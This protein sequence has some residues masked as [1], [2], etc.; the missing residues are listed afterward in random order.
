MRKIFLYSLLL[1]I[2]LIGSQ[3][4][5]E[6]VGSSDHLVFEIINFL[7]MITLAYI[8]IK[9][10]LEFEIDKSKIKSYAWDYLVAMVSAA[11]PW[12]FVAFYFSSLLSREFFT[13]WDTWKELLL[14]SRFAAP[15]SAGVL[16][17]MLAAAGLSATWL[18]K[19]IRILAIFDDLDTILFMI[20]LQIVFIG[21]VWQL[22]VLLPFILLL[23]V[24]AWKYSSLL[25]IPHS[26]LWL[27][28]YALLITSF[29][30]VIYLASKIID[31]T[32]PVHFEVLLPSF[33]LGVVM[34]HYE[35]E[36]KSSNVSVSSAISLVF[37]FL[38]GLSMPQIFS[39][40]PAKVLVEQSITASL[41]PMSWT[42]LAFHVV[43]VTIISNIGKM[44]PVFCY[45]KEAH[46][47]EKLALSIGMWPR[48]EVGAGILIIS[49]SHNIGG[50]IIIIAM[51]SLALNLLLIGPC[52]YLIKY[53]IQERQ[54]DTTFNSNQMEQ[55][56]N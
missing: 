55:A 14:V 34:K 4:L 23:L 22:G 26:W 47:K 48:G 16:F 27:L 9:V 31:E 18:F 5:P 19:K 28:F 38:V 15:T 42:A 43:M 40:E 1:V 11:L 39:H 20:P 44:F 17:S 29:S 7:M 36:K 6:I 30:E 49:L 37:M 25:K 10:G 41:P 46:W 3:L 2:G 12:I 32:V 56:A 35:A 8:M 51:L 24:V 52:I 13:M 45:R 54:G 21:F 50:P 33:V 53:L